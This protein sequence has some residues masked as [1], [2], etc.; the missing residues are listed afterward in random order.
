MT[1]FRQFFDELPYQRVKAIIKLANNASR[2]VEEDELEG[3]DT[4]H[5]LPVCVVGTIAS[6]VQPLSGAN[7]AVYYRSFRGNSQLQTNPLDDQSWSLYTSSDRSD[8]GF[9]P[10]LSCKAIAAG[11]FADLSNGA[12]AGVELWYNNTSSEISKIRFFF[13]LHR[14]GYVASLEWNMWSGG[15]TLR[16]NKFPDGRVSDQVCPQHEENSIDGMTNRWGMF[17]WP[18]QTS[19]NDPPA[20]VV[21]YP[22]P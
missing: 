16:P 18:D 20:I 7:G 21:G 14:A 17:E 4:H 13:G 10:E 5:N 12:Q 11:P 22:N 8:M 1:A 9:I 15:V 19:R 2:T 3:D 6:W